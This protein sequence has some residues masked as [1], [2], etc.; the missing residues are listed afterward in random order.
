M[1]TDRNKVW[2]QKFSNSYIIRFL[3][4]IL[5]VIV[6]VTVA[7]YKLSKP[8]KQNI[9][10][11]DERESQNLCNN[12]CDSLIYCG[13]D[14]LKGYS[15]SI[16]MNVKSACYTGC[17]KHTDSLFECSTLLKEKSAQTK[18]DC[19]Q[20]KEC[21]QISNKSFQQPKNRPTNKK[22]E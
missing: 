2:R 8:K 4:L 17:V 14:Y 19:N 7:A 20:L 6:T 11:I 18:N 15:E 16:I 13:S 22:E 1:T 10:F 9:E 12:F 21:L 3:P 5:I